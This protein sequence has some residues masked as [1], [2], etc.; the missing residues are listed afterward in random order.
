[1]TRKNYW[2][3]AAQ[4]LTAAFVVAL[5][6]ATVV[7]A[8]AVTYDPIT[9]TGSTW[10]QN[11][12]DQWRKNV[13][14]NY[15]MTVNYSGVGSSAGRRDFAAG[16]VDYAVSEI[17]FQSK[18]EDGSA[19]EVPT[20]GFAYMPIVAG[21][22]SFMYNL[23]IGG[24]RVSNLRL[25]GETITKIFT[26]VI[27]KWN[28]PIIATDN[29]GLTMPDKG[30]VPVV[31]SDGSGST[32]QFTLWM[33]KQHPALWNSYC[34][35]VGKA[36]PCGLTSQYP[37]TGNMKGQSGSSGVAGY[38]SQDY[39]EGAITYV[40]YSYALE[41][42]YPVAKVLNASGYYVEPT[43]PSVAVALMQAQINTTPGP[44]YLTQILDGVYNSTDPRTYPL[45][46]YSYMIVPTEVVAGGVF[47]AKKGATLGAFASYML[48]E[49]Q[50]QAEALGYS[51]LPMNLVLA[52]FDQI[53]RI[54]GAAPA[55]DPNACNNPTF[56]PGDSP[57]NNQ[58]ALTAPQP[59][60]CD[61]VGANQ[62][63]TGTGGSLAETP[64]SGAGT[65]GTASN[66][67]AGSA[68]PATAAA[69][70]AAGAAAG[71]TAS[72]DENGALISG[73]GISG[74]AVASPFT[75][76]SSAWGSGQ[77]TMLFAAVLLLAAALLPPLIWPRLKRT[78]AKVVA[79]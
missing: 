5:S 39:G 68:D 72:Y 62:C 19:P 3:R 27:T 54:P 7:P 37:L 75:L 32:A 45:S 29:P 66:A 1:M 57:S 63:T 58:L 13:A 38:V 24:V 23:K 44:D 40:E 8:Q 47:T 65:G 25:S 71:V 12:L 43:A 41:S 42:G 20:R 21:G 48:C 61:K 73:T 53:G 70:G 52:G 15:G 17:P 50:Q 46:S 31:R 9:G 76:A 64:I 4:T 22:S 2:A 14:A 10:S 79:K 77:S 55:P 59:A 60:E 36:T 16:S 51:P 35:S 33:S 6:V 74:S 18:P 78:P 28:D 49:G 30:I 67:V 56:K 11:A 26:G 69:A 34:A